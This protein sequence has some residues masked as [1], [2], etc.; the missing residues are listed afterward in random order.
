MVRR[1][2]LVV[3]PLDDGALTD[4]ANSVADAI[5]LDLAS[6][7]PEHQ[8]GDAR[9]A[10]AFPLERLS[11]GG[12]ELLL[13]TDA[14][15][16]EA[17]LTACGRGAIVGVLTAVDTPEEVHIIH[18][19]LNRWEAANNVPTSA[20]TLELVVATAKAVQNADRLAA[21]SPRTVAMALDDAMLLGE[22]GVATPDTSDTLLYHRGRMAVAARSAGIQAHALYYA[23]ATAHDRAVVARQTGLRGSL[24]FNP[25]D[26]A[27][28][29]VGFSP[30]RHEVDA[31]RQ[32]LDAMQVA[33][34]GGRGSVAVSS[35][36]MA[37]LANVRG[38]N[39]IIA[40]D[41]AVQ[42]RDAAKTMTIAPSS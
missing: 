31:A 3:S 23:G 25:D 10:T 28:I 12:A 9:R 36:Q 34:E 39:S 37:D 2:L 8:R 16:I 13:W 11:S 40:W 38:A 20:T 4:A 6:R 41:E 27:A 29:N 5:V 24:C 35:G 1:S 19:A 18:E 22:L 14:D 32:V 15:G 26:V 17:D 42:R 21:A 30:S 7:I 33:I